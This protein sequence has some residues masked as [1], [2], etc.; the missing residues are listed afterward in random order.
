MGSPAI[1]SAPAYSLTVYSLTPVDVPGRGFVTRRA[2]IARVTTRNTSVA[3]PVGLLAP[4]GV[5]SFT[6]ETAISATP[7]SAPYRATVPFARCSVSSAM[8]TP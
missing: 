4:G 2:Q 5:Y 6:L 7:E 1:G 8:F 3:L